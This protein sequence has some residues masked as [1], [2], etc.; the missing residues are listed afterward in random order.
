MSW[1]SS[2]NL[3]SLLLTPKQ[4]HNRE[5]KKGEKIRIV[6]HL[7]QKKNTLRERVEIV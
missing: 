3:F 2:I 1:L 4:R 5:I 6:K 7:K